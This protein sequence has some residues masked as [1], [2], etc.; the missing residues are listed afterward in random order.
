MEGLRERLATVTGATAEARRSHRARLVDGALLELAADAGLSTA[1]V[2]LAAVGGYGRGELSPHSDLDL[3]L[4]HSIE[5]PASYATLLAERLWYPIWDAGI[6]LDHSV[7]SVG[8]ARQLARSDLTVLLGMLDLR[9]IAGDPSVTAELSRRVL[10]HWRADAPARLPDLLESC[11]VRAGRSGELA[12]ASVPDLK[13]S[14]GGLHDLVVMRAVAA[15]W[16]ADFPH[17]GVASARAEL[18]DVRD[19]LREL[20]GRAVDRIQL[21]DQDALAEALGLADRDALMRR[22]AGIGRAVAH[23]ADLTWYRV[24]RTIRRPGGS[25]AAGTTSGANGAWSTIG[26]TGVSAASGVI[27]ASRT[28]GVT[29]PSGLSSTSGTPGASGTIIAVGGGRPVRRPLADGVVEQDGEAVLARTADPADPT[30]VLRLAAAAARAG[31]PVS[32]SGLARL[33]RVARPMPVPWPEPARRAMLALL[34]AGE[35][36]LPVWE[37]L[38]QAGVVAG[39]LPGW[40][41]LRSLPQR[42]PVHRHTV[43]RHLMQ[44]AVEASALLRS[45]ARPDLL[46][47]AALLHDVGKGTG[48]DHSAAGAEITA[49]WLARMGVPEP[50]ATEI[51]WLVR[52]HL[53][54]AETATRRDPDDSATVA[55]VASAVGGPGR[56]D[57][58]LAL[59]EADAVAAGPRAWTPWKAAQVRTLADRVRGMLAGEAA[60]DS[61]EPDG[62]AGPELR[63]QGEVVRGQLRQAGSAASVTGR[64]AGRGD[65]V[66]GRTAG[67]ADSVTGRRDGPGEPT[68]TGREPDIEVTVTDPGTGGEP[69]IEVT[70]TDLGTAVTVRTA[71]RPGLLAT[72]AGV[73]ELH[74]LSVRA[75]AAD[76]D[77]TLA[78]QSWIAEA[79]F[80]GGPEPDAVRADLRRALSGLLDPAARL[81]RRRRP[82]GPTRSVRP[83]GA[84]PLVR[85]V[86]EASRS[87]TVLEVRAPDVPGLLTAVAGAVTAAGVDVVAARVDTY[88]A[89][90]VDVFYLRHADGPLDAQQQQDVLDAVRAAMTEPDIAPLAPPTPSSPVR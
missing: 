43:D 62:E 15:S 75:A 37:A 20:T 57:L 38:D 73:L 23:A 52:H 31:I 30:M 69:S 48:G 12:F 7:R 86:P 60:V 88:G 81:A 33:V 53:L 4:L 6:A 3:V 84:A 19:A 9:H 68:G 25:F 1:G 58:L 26:A 82:T 27:G 28:S 59:T 16:V 89:D 51:A 49:P 78:R 67:P 64:L 10:A 8:A 32:P 34:G 13:Q 11:R 66:T 65:A 61:A 39:L 45:V 42:D 14:R 2:A 22:I 41:R 79:Q 74:R 35:P 71:D 54:L 47:L 24:G 17:A 36:M 83:A 70:V 72:V 44:T 21:Q 18:L 40:D 56:L 55:A 77:G 76:T 50:D 80:G 29:G 63:R 87:S 90:A 46:L 85:I 5:T